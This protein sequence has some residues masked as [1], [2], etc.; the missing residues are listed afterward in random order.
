MGIITLGNGQI[1]SRFRRTYK[2]VENTMIIRAKVIVLEDNP[3]ET[4]KIHKVVTDAGH[5]CT[6]FMTGKAMIAALSRDMYDMLILDWN[7]CDM[8]GI[9]VLNWVKENIGENIA[10]I[11]LMASAPEK[12]TVAILM[13]GADDCIAKP[14]REAELS[15]RIHAIARR[16]HKFLS[17]NVPPA[18]PTVSS[19]E[20]GIYY[21]DLLRRTVSVGGEQIDLKPKEFDMAVLF[22]KNIGTQISRERII[23]EIWGRKIGVKSRTLDTHVSQLRNKL[24]LKVETQVSLTSIY[25]FGYRLDVC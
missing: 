4:R 25:M 8:E 18:M 10:I 15:A 19:L 20:V 9:G 24:Q 14:V 11:V 1:D 6:T 16:R 21:F 22:F 17:D 13:A 2:V 7:I 3:T 5:E 12:D 23:G